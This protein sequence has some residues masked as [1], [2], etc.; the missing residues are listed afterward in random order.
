MLFPTPKDRTHAG[1]QFAESEGFADIVV[2]TQFQT[3]NP[4]DLVA[5]MSRN[6]DYGDVESRPDLPQQ[7]ESVIALKTQVEQNEARLVSCD[8]T[9][10]VLPP[11]SR[12]RVHVLLPQIVA[13]H[14]PH[15]RIVVHNQ[16]ASI[17][18]VRRIHRHSFR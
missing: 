4:V 17:S 16:D 14:A 13:E 5:A 1:Q 7:I 12:Q 18:S 11:G 3:H 2:S 8:I 6:D 15:A 10:H 9:Q